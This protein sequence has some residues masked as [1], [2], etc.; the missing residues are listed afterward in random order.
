MKHL[1]HFLLWLIIG[2]AL[3][4]SDFKYPESAPDPRRYD[5]LYVLYPDIAVDLSRVP[6]RDRGYTG[7]GERAEE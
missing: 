7:Y 6:E 2:L 1:W 3:C 5:G 4:I